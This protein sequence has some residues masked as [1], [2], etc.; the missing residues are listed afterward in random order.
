M[1]SI[2]QPVNHYVPESKV[3]NAD[4][5]NILLET[6]PRVADASI[7]TIELF[8]PEDNLTPTVVE[9]RDRLEKEGGE[10]YQIAIGAKET[11][12]KYQMAK[13]K[14]YREIKS[15]ELTKG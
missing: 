6:T 15:T 10:E 9:W 2:Y 7:F 1:F 4:F 11:I 8:S 5:T 13:D 12:E 3:G 14:Q